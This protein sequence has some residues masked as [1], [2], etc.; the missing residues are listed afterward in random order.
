ME[1]KVAWTYSLEAELEKARRHLANLQGE[2]DDRT[3]WALKRD[4]E[5][6]AVRADLRRISGSFCYQLGKKLLLIPAPHFKRGRQ[7]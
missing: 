7:G 5:L 2:I 6:K 1:S 4:A 3:V